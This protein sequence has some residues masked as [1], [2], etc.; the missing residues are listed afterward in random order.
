MLK[1][2]PGDMYKTPR[3][4]LLIVSKIRCFYANTLYEFESCDD[5]QYC[6]LLKLK[7]SGYV[8]PE[9]CVKNVFL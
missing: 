1:F 7:N 2:F 4:F 5:A 3:S 8:Q 6:S 9:L